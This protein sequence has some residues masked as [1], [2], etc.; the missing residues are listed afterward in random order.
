MLLVVGV[1]VDSFIAILRNNL[2]TLAATVPSSLTLG[3]PVSLNVVDS[4]AFVG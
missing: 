4:S 2:H 1:L 3:G